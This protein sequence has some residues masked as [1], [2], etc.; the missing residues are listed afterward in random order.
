MNDDFRE[1]DPL[2]ELLG[3]APPRPASTAFSRNV[4][5]AIRT[6]DSPAQEKPFLAGFSRWFLPAGA[7][8]ALALVLGV[9]LQP[10]TE[11]VANPVAATDFYETLTFR[12]VAGL[13]DLVASSAGWTWEDVAP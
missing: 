8:A 1:N 11:I 7:V 9:A 6:Q 2:W 13:D 5:R 3:K 4:I 10:P 12:E